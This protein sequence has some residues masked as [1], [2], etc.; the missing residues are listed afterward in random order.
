MCFYEYCV[1]AAA[2]SRPPCPPSRAG[3]RG[4]PGPG[5]SSPRCRTASRAATSPALLWPVP[6]NSSKLA[7]NIQIRVK[8]SLKWHLND[9][10]EWLI[11][12]RNQ[13]VGLVLLKQDWGIGPRTKRLDMGGNW[14]DH[15]TR[16]GTYISEFGFRSSLF[17][18]RSFAHFLSFVVTSCSKE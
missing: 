15:L 3:R 9:I 14:G 2:P 13:D 16:N 12:F 18:F 1:P 4:R 8:W 10:F 7:N 17:R 5:P 11:H 6:C